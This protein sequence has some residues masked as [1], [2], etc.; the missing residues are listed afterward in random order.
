MFF[1]IWSHN[2][3]LWISLW[4]CCWHFRFSTSRVNFNILHKN[5]EHILK[6][7]SFLH[8]FPVFFICTYLRQDLDRFYLCLLPASSGMKT[9]TV[10]SPL[11]VPYL[12]F[13]RMLYLPESDVFTPMMVKLANLPDANLRMQWSSDV[14]SLSFFSQVTSGTGSPEMLQVRL[15]VWWEDNAQHTHTILYSH[16]NCVQ[17]HRVILSITLIVLQD[18]GLWK[19]ISTSVMGKKNL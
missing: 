6:P 19:H 11:S 3:S 9:L 1:R 4:T 13:T 8:L 15:R 2:S 16:N 18:T 7:V 5:I 14:I 12:F 10:K 17:K